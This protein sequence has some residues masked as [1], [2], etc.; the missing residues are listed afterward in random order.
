MFKFIEKE[1]SNQHR[2]RSRWLDKKIGETA[3][4]NI[5]WDDS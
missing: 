2:E 3:M 5:D 1:P 4:R